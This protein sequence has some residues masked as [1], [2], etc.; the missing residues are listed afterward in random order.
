MPLFLWDYGPL[1]KVSMVMGEAWRF[2]NRLKG[3]RTG[4]WDGSWGG[5]G[6]GIVTRVTDNPVIFHNVPAYSG[7]G[8]FGDELRPASLR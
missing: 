4:P 7:L 5:P 6:D 1:D 2:R 3:L 8:A